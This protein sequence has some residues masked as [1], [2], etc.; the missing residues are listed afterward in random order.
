MKNI[1][2]IVNFIRARDPRSTEAELKEAVIN[3]MKLAEQYELPTTFLF[4]HDALVREDF[5]A[6]VR[7]HDYIEIGLWLELNQDLVE[8]AGGK[9]NGRE[10]YF[11]D[12]YSHADLTVGYAPEIRKK[13]IDIA[14]E[15]FKKAFGEY[16]KTVG[17]W[18][19]DAV[20]LK[21]LQDNYRI[22]ASF[23]C[24]DQW[25]T[26]GYSLWRGYYNQAFYPSVHNAFCPANSEE[27]Q[28]NIPIFRMLGSDPIEQYDCESDDNGQNVVSLEPVYVDGG[29]NE[30]WVRWFFGEMFN[31]KSMSFGYTQAGQ[32]NAFTWPKMKVGY[33]MQMRVIDE[34]RKAGKFDVML[35]AEAGE[36]Y[37]NRYAVTPASTIVAEHEGKGAIWY[38]NRF[39]RLGAY[40]EENVFFIRDITLFRDSYPERYLNDT[41]KDRNMQY[42]NLPFMDN[43]KWSR[44]DK[45]AGVY[46][47]QNGTPAKPTGFA[48]TKEISPTCFEIYVPFANE[49][50]VI[51]CEENKLTIQT[52]MTVQFVCDA[53]DMD[54]E[55]RFAENEIGCRYNGFAYTVKVN[56]NV[57]ETGEIAPVNGTVEFVF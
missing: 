37:K 6:L 33:E 34:F 15:D 38:F 44:N 18:L 50:A 21:Y 16:P 35:A 25:G 29:G 3:Q 40:C 17:S 32:E 14:M 8:R 27:T 7:K 51:R 39:F 30:T 52:D 23:N 9:W 49:T 10:G 5:T 4:Q 48:K 22:S 31:G 19:I 36:W 28:I 57:S 46:F 2:T 54:A 24:K 47:L 55:L 42:D 56:G 41:C 53:A 20:T 13:M 45:K 1:I 26:D 43:Y 11:W 12:W